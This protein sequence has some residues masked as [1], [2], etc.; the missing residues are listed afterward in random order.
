M[1]RK[2][3][4]MPA[5]FAWEV[6]DKC[7]WAT[8]ATVDCEG[9]PYCVTLSIARNGEYIYFHCAVEGFKIDCLRR[10]GEVCMTFVGDTRRATKSFTTGYE[11][12]C[13]RGRAEEVTDTEEKIEAL[14]LLCVRHTPANMSNFDAAVR[15]SLARTAIWRVKVYEITGKRKVLRSE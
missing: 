1:R 12:A 2:D 6:V 3:R 13:I 4:E 15:G 14:R 7:E 8:L 5:E 9:K 10:S 11:S